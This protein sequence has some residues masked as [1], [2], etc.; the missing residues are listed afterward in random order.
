MSATL[1]ASTDK[2][3]KHFMAEMH[4]KW[5]DQ[6]NENMWMCALKEYGNDETDSARY[7][8]DLRLN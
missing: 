4:E 1:N 5:L 8:N 6:Q 2:L 7:N 3:W